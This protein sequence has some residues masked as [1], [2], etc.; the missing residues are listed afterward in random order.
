MEVMNELS[1]K[2]L[3]LGVSSLDIREDFSETVAIELR[4][5][6]WVGSRH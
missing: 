4:T 3:T 1:I 6:A 2:L 5:E